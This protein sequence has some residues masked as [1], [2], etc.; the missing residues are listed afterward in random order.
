[1]MKSTCWISYTN[2]SS[3]SKQNEQATQINNSK[4]SNFISMIPRVAYQN[5]LDLYLDH[6]GLFG[7][8]Q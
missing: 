4:R 8:I 1:M 3:A 6:G 7:F 5:P 2:P